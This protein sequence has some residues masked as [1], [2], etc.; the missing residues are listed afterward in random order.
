[1]KLNALILAGGKSSRMGQDKGKLKYYD[2]YQTEHL[3]NILAP[4]VDEVFVSVREVQLNEPHVKNV[5]TIVDTDDSVGPMSGILAAMNEDPQASWL[6]LAVDLPFVTKSTIQKL[7]EN[8]DLTKNVTCFKN[9]EKGWPEPLCSIWESS[10]KKDLEK[11]YTEKKYCPR[12]VLFNTDISM[13]ELDELNTL[14]N[15][16][17]NDDYLNATKNIK[18]NT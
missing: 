7:I 9:P 13:L 14:I 4:Y 8:R 3:Q 16:N 11:F 1:M 18:V 17:T 6:V 5:K 2:R 10:A 15:C 12:K